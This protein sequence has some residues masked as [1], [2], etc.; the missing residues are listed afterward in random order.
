MAAVV[1]LFAVVVS[2]V[3][4]QTLTTQSSLTVRN[5]VQ[6]RDQARSGLEMAL[7]QLRDAKGAGTPL[8]ACR[9]NQLGLPQSAAGQAVA[10]DEQTC[11]NQQVRKGPQSMLLGGGCVTWWFG[12]VD[13]VEQTVQV[14]VATVAPYVPRDGDDQACNLSGL[15]SSGDDNT[16]IINAQGGITYQLN[17]TIS[18]YVASG[19]PQG[20]SA[21]DGY[22]DPCP[23]TPITTS[24]CVLRVSYDKRTFNL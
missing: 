13:E 6:S 18:T 19:V 7:Q 5:D 8:T 11:S 17:A 23:S 2:R 20:A 3:Q 9:L 16:S 10:D 4:L 15:L 14:H 24:P 12:L 21:A 22:G 1:I